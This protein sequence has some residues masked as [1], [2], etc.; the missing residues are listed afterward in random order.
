MDRA[1]R[2]KMMH[3]GVAITV[4]LAFQGAALAAAPVNQD[5]FARA[6]QAR[7]EVTS[8][9]ERLVNIDSG[10]GSEKGLD[11]VGAIVAAEAKKLGM[12]VDFSSAAP[13]VGH[14]L[15]ATLSGTGTA[16]IL[17]MAHMD[18]VFADGTAAARPF[19]IQGERAYGPGVMDD[20]G[21]IVIALYAIRLL[22][23]MQFTNFKQITLLV[24]TNEETSSKGTVKLIAALAQQHDVTLNLEPGRVADGLVVWRKG[25]A[26][27]QIDVKGKSA[28]AGVAPEAGRNAAMEAAHQM[29]QM[30]TLGDDA[31]KTTV[32]FTVFHAGERSNVIPNAALVRGDMRATDAAEFDR[33]EQGM[34]RMA[35]KKQIAGTEVSTRLVRG[36]P[37][38]PATPRTA[39]LAARAQAIYGELGMKLTMEGSGGAA[40]ANFASGAGAATLDGFGIVGG[41]IHTEDEYA[42]LNSIAPRLYLLTRMIMDVSTTPV[43]R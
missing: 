4:A 34:A 21:G 9:L 39:A 28:H 23:Q 5:L 2:H 22:Q 16:R 8:L 40:D 30:A 42:E 26:D 3:C 31:K 18:T 37:P 20:K 24:N 10:T 27:L 35:E 43:P 32:N 19:R 6:T 12:R 14:N 25:T 7:P 33:V 38:M 13:A 17:L 36:M 15:V 29:L 11:Q 1:A 41:A